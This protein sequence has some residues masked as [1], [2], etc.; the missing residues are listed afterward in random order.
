MLCSSCGKQ[1][2]DLHPKK[3]RLMSGVT[4]YLCDGCARAKMEP[5]YIIILVGRAEGTPAVADYIRNHRYIGQ[6]ILAKE[7]IP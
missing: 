3:S 6:D 1:K 2:A 4:L 5:R 7:L